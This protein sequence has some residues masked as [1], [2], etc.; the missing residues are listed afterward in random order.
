[1]PSFPTYRPRRLRRTE[2]M[3]RLVRETQLAPAQ[4]VLPM[5]VR[6]G[7]GVRQA[8]GSMPGVCQ[9]SVDEMLRDAR[10]AERL[11]VGGVLL[12]GIPDTKDAIGSAAWGGRGPGQEA[13]RALKRE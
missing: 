10:E 7:Q 9:T 11:G 5:F 13:V 4:L 12:F 3:R 8:V 6:S 2:A 1:M